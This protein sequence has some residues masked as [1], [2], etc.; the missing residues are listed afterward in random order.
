MKYT[1]PELTTS[2]LM[3][4]RG[5]DDDFKAV[6]EYDFRKLRDVGGEFVYVKLDP[7]ML[8]GFADDADEEDTLNW[9][10]FLKDSMMSKL[11]LLSAIFLIANSR[12]V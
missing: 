4:K 1:T 7:A 6:Y 10:L 11:V 8:D 3:L 2:R 9:V 12:G 5:T